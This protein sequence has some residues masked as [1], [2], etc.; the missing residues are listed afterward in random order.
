MQHGDHQNRIALRDALLRQI[1]AA[2][3]NV[4]LGGG[5]S[6]HQADAIDDYEDDNVI[7]KARDLDTEVRWQDV[8]DDKLV[9]FQSVLPFLDAEG[10]RFYFP[11]FMTF[12]L[13]HAD[14]ESA[15]P[16]TAIYWSDMDA[17]PRRSSA[18][19]V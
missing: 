11:R 17:R 10:F 12:A 15:V 1:E 14:S 5:R 6:M 18:I 2:F 13:R 8:S 4:R 16:D 19:V 3:G 9:R 7:A